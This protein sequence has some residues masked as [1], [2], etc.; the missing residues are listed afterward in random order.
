[1]EF[2]K[3]ININNY[4]EGLKF[5]CLC[6]NFNSESVKFKD[7]LIKNNPFL[8]DFSQEKKINNDDYSIFIL[9]GGDGFALHVINKLLQDKLIF[10]DKTFFYGINYGNV[11]FLMN[12]IREE[13]HYFDLKNLILN[14]K[15]NKINPLVIK[16][17]N[18]DCEKSIYYKN[19]DSVEKKTDLLYAINDISFLRNSSQAT[20]IKLTIDGVVRISELVGDGLI[21][22]TPI[23]STA[24]NFSAGGQ[25][26]PIS[27]KLLSIR[28]LNTSRPRLWCGATISSDCEILVE[29]LE[30]FKRPVCM[31]CDHIQFSANSNKFTIKS[32]KD[33]EVNLLFD[34]DFDLPEKV[35]MRQFFQD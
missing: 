15:I 11:G 5:Y 4:Q 14:S 10:G 26:I 23:G 12:K 30:S 27:S 7:V 2:N 13:S 21:V 6:D 33:I 3:F 24:Y 9:I 29:M 31:S 1:M 34:S 25:I 18:D 17:I 35:L 19:I 32:T 8:I 16:A 20:K 28:S 22:S